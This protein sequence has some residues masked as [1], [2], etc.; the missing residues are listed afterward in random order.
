MIAVDT[1]VVV[2]LLTQ[3]HPAQSARAVAVF[4]S[5]RVRIAK[6]VLLETAWVLSYAYG[7]A[8]PAIARVLRGLAGLPNVELEDERAV[9]EALGAMERGLDFADAL[10]LASHGDA[11]RFV[12]FDRRLAKRAA[13]IAPLKTN[14]PDAPG[15][16][17]RPIRTPPDRAISCVELGLS[18]DCG[19]A[20]LF[21]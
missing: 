1:D 18:D 2:R 3:D 15:G 21:R 16:S 11:E 17:R 8:D 13:A 19:E 5:D 4:R 10:H 9:A 12:T 20:Y 7:L 14:F 6:T